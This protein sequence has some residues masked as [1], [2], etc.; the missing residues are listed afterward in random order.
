MQRD[1]SI[2]LEVKG[3]RFSSQKRRNR[4]KTIETQLLINVEIKPEENYWTQ[5]QFPS[6]L[7][8]DKKSQSC[9]LSFEDDTKSVAGQKEALVYYLAYFLPKTAQK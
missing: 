1:V 5:S 2:N 8:W 3:S 9:F 6:V 4:N 7:N